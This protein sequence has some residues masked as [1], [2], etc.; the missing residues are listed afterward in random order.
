MKSFWG[1]KIVE[2][3][4][5]IAVILTVSYLPFS[6]FLGNSLSFTTYLERLASPKDIA[7]IDTNTM[8]S[9]PFFERIMEPYTYS[10]T[11]LLIAT[12]LTIILQLVFIRI[13][14]SFF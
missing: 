7:H 8:Q 13:L 1:G 3:L 5:S 6:L 12:C 10:M 4:I 9:I 11:I 2:F 14:I